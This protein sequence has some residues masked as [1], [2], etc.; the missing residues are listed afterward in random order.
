MVRFDALKSALIDNV[1]QD[2]PQSDSQ[3][4]PQELSEIQQKIFKCIKND[5]KISREKIAEKIG[6]S[7]KTVA[8][9]LADMKDYVQFIGRGYSGHWEVISLTEGE[10]KAPK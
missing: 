1:P 8:R 9:N 5:S 7:K 4:V 3:A 2:D 6:V 10:K